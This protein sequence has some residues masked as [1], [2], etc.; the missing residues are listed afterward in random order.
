MISWLFYHSLFLN[1][2]YSKDDSYKKNINYKV[3]LY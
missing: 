2:I 3:E 1:A